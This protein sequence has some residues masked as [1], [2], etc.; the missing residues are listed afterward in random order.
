MEKQ[1]QS[2][3]PKGGFI[4]LYRG[5]NQHWLWGDAEKLKWWIDILFEVNYEPKKV[6]IGG[7]LIQCERGQVLY[8]LQTW[9]TRWRVD[10]N[11]VRRFFSLLESDGMIETKSA[12]KTTCLTVCNYAS[13]NDWRQDG[14]TEVTGSRQDGDTEVTT[15][16][17][18]QEGKEGKERKKTSP[19]NKKGQAGVPPTEQE[20]IS[21]FAENGY[22]ETAARKA[23]KYYNDADWFDSQGNKVRAWKQKMI[24]VWFKPENKATTQP[25]ADRPRINHLSIPLEHNLWQQ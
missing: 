10:V 8:S 9:A 2:E 17:E 19:K 16:E 1:P 21:Y 3:P 24:S 4:K 12:G 22:T 23:F 15:T 14:D 7:T 20:V 5:V 18:G 13:Y 25:G 11:K 6:L